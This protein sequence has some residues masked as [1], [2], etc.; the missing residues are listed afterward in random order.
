MKI[1]IIGNSHV[2]IFSGKSTILNK[3][4]SHVETYT[5]TPNITYCSYHIGPTIAY[6]FFE[7]HYHHVT[8]ICERFVN[9]DTDYIMIVVGEVDCRWHL[10]KQASIQH[11]EIDTLVDEC[12]T[13]FFRCY[14]DL[15][16]KG[17]KCIGWGGHPST[18]GGHNDDPNSPVYGDVNRRNNISK[19]FEYTIKQKCIE[20]NM[21]F[22]SI[23]HECINDDNTTDMTY[24][25]DYCHLNA[26]KILPKIN[27]L[28]IS[29]LNLQN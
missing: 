5:P 15:S 16:N 1:H 12:V 25:I 8:D 27:E 9:K 19:L 22:I 7:H 21:P 11:I 26:D 2:S 28:V 17:Y 14:R 23:L 18:N 10:P 13:R 29:Y 6:N 24:F 4:P 20:N 3:Y